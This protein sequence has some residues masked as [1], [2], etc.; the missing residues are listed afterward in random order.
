MKKMEGKICCRGL[1]IVVWWR[2]RIHRRSVVVMKDSTSNRPNKI[3]TGNL[4][5]L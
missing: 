4:P 5:D 2:E 1:T 3:I